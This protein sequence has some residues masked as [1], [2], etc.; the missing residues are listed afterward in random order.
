MK[1][2]I[3]GAT[4][5]IGRRLCQLLTGEGHKVVALSRSP[6][7][8]KDIAI[9]EAHKWEPGV[10]PP[11]DEALNGVDAVVHLAGE[12][13]ATRRWSDEQKGRIRESRVASTRNLVNA[14]RLMAIKPRVL[15]SSSAV[16]F[17]GDRGDEL[18]IE[19]SAAGTGFMSEVCESWEQEAERARLFGVRVVEVRTGVVLSAEG[20]ALK[21]ML[22]PIKLGVGGPLGSGKQ[23]FPWIH[24]EDIVGIFRH[25]IHSPSLSGPVNGTAPGLANNAEFTKQLGRVL[26]R[27][28]FLSVPE[29]ALR[30]LMG[31]MAD[32]LLGSQR[33]I[34]KAMLDDG[35]KFQYPALTLALEN[36]LCEKG[37]RARA[38]TN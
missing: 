34:P 3:T 13:I 15:V 28:T 24:I 20:G 6:Q 29:F 23:W 31:E 9:V 35:Y 27:P 36:L 7:R 1:I 4:G 26:H 11:P 19:S 5:L 12:P 25:T 14:L 30:G 16:G 22:P 21:K 18:L 38:A 8:A 37:S 2:L 10:G 17:Y 32:V 33:V